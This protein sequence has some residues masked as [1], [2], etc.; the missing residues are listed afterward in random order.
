MSA[1]AD[2]AST[3]A[4]AR[5]RSRALPRLCI[6]AASVIATLAATELGLRLLFRGDVERVLATRRRQV[7]PDAAGV[8]C[9]GDSYTFGLY[10]RPE[11]A[12][13]GRLELLLNAGTEAGSGGHRRWFVENSG[14]PAQNSAQMAARLPEQLDRLKPKV[15]VVLAGFNDRWNFAPPSR[16]A[17]TTVDRAHDGSWIDQ[18]VL[19]K[20]VRLVLANEPAAVALDG[21]TRLAQ[22]TE[23][24]IEVAGDEGDNAIDIRKTGQRLVDEEHYVAVATRLREMVAVVRAAG[25]L[26]FLCSYPS[27][28]PHYEPPSRAAAD[29]ARETSVPFVDLRTL[30]A[31]ELEHAAYE[32]LLIPG[33]RHPTDRGY[34]RM[35][36]AVAAAMQAAGAWQPTEPLATE[37]PAAERRGF[38]LT[39]Q[40]EQLYPVTLV[41]EAGEGAPPRFALTGPPNAHWKLLV[42][43]AETP[44][45]QFGPLTLRLAADRWF[46]ASAADERCEGT[47]DADGRAIWTLPA[48]FADARFVALAVLHDLLV[49]AEALQVR[50]LAGPLPLR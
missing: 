9:I 3:A 44:S 50:G 22:F 37:L 43:G 10:Y 28:E 33:D 27:P 45:Q 20:F 13:P 25:A 21:K 48:E 23:S 41:R 40:R 29:V 8:L 19:V 6:V 12:Y 15:V 17:T 14:I 1:P 24:H 38:T 4:P 35:A 34:W 31:R 16:A 11:E 32:S 36:V 7:A 26:P 47:F 5:R 18:W 46:S 30:F 2:C 39:G 49:G 42:A